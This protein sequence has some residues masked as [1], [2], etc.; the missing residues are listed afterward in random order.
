MN[1][2]AFSATRKAMVTAY[3]EAKT[4]THGLVSQGAQR[5]VEFQTKRQRKELLSQLLL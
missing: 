2:R 4:S 3:S 5:H 1:L